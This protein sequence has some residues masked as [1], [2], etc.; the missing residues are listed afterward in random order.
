L[1]FHFF[2]ELTAWCCASFTGAA[3]VTALPSAEISRFSAPE[4]RQAVAVDARFFYAIANQTIAKYDK[5]NGKLI[6][7]WHA[8]EHLPL[9]HLNSGVVIHGELF[10]A[11]SNFPQYPEASSIEV[12][13]TDTLQH[14]RSHSLG[15]FE[16]SLTWIDWQDSSWWAAFAHYSLNIN[17]SPHGR[18]SSWTSLVKFDRQ[19]RRT[20]GW[21][22]PANVIARFEPHS[23]SG[24]SWGP[25]G[26]LYCTGHD[27]GELYA[28]ALPKAGST[29]VLRACYKVPFTGQGFAWDPSAP[30][31]ALG[32][33]RTEGQ[34]IRVR[35]S[36]I[37]VGKPVLAT[38]DLPS[39][40]P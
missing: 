26:L 17:G 31:S 20:A 11:H 12:W 25:D 28:L 35:L 5:F 3:E 36:G 29:L 19:W 15:I 39:T 32:I 1:R 40:D 4:A 18:D 21:V 13:D 34:V 33:D 14:L 7:R 8:S 24:G 37:A 38:E 9:K 16:G 27:C 2:V 10:C 22:F 6:S 30:A 23:C